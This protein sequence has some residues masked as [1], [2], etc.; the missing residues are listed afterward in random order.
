MNIKVKRLFLVA[1]YDRDG[2]VDDS[3]IYYTRKLNRFGDIILC[4]D[5][6]APESE[7]EK[8]KPYCMHVMATRHGE[9]DFGSYK[10]AYQWARDNGILRDYICVYLINDSVY[11]PL[12]DMDD[13]FRKMESTHTNASS[14]VISNHRTHSFME[15]WFIKLDKKIFLMPWFDEFISSVT[16]EPN[17][18][19][20]TIKYEHGLTNLIKNN[21]CN[22]RGLYLVRGRYTY[23]HPKELTMHG[24]PFIKKASFTRHNG[25]IGKQ[26]KYVLDKTN[27][28]TRTAIMNSANRLYGVKY[29]KW[30]L[31]SNPFK[32]LI[33]NIKYATKKIKDAK[34]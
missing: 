34:I 30:L 33:R 6:D 1:A 27:V 4:M 19:Q 21:G 23:N 11:G 5:C 8:L 22:V 12:F 26:L 16:T 14:I 15:S 24:C 7:L 18:N 31:T 2:I 10:R 28:I 32:I 3:L 13:T 9:Y 17:K 25:A 29:M 20:I